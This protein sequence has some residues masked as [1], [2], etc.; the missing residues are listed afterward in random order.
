VKEIAM[1]STQRNRGEAPA[2]GDGQDRPAAASLGWASPIRVEPGRS[3]ALAIALAL[4]LTALG[5]APAAAEAQ[6]LTVP[7]S[8]PGRPASVDVGLVMGSIHVVAGR[9]GEV[10]IET[11][12]SS[13]D[14]CDDCGPVAGKAKDKP[15]KEQRGLDAGLRRIPYDA[16]DLTAEEDG[17]QVT[18]RSGG[19]PRQLELR[20]VVPPGSSL[21]LSTVNSGELDVEGI[22]G[23]IELHNTNG[24]IRARG[25]R[26]PVTANTVNGDV[27]IEFAPGTTIGGPMAFST[28]NG[29]VDVTL[30]PGVDADLRVRT[31]HGEIY[32][33][34]D[35]ELTPEPAQV[36]RDGSRGRYRLTV[37]KELHG[38]IGGGGHELFLKSFNGDIVLRR[39]GG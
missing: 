16:V 6:R 29:D 27:E 32:S 19:I 30:P 20:V 18:V 22:T 31:E 17:N 10:V 36:E 26:G 39:A 21:R 4:A 15:S 1:W 12:G 8:N 11:Q 13:D 3:P 2:R 34:F 37:A 38:R 25:V 9:A 14:D 33:D 24:P 35:V 23:E 5:A 28:L 7:L